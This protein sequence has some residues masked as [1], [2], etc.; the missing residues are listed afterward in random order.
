ME[1]SKEILLSADCCRKDCCRKDCCKKGVDGRLGCVHA[2][3]KASVLSIWTM[4]ASTGAVPR[5]A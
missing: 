2:P 5:A 1:G 3:A 4:V